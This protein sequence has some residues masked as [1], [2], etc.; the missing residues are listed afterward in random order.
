MTEANPSWPALPLKAWEPTRATLHMWT[1]IVGKVRLA[2][3]PYLNHWWQVP[4][5]VSP[6]G[7]ATSPIPAG[8]ESFE[9]LFDFL[10]HE[11]R[12]EKSDG[13]TSTLPLSPRPV[14]DFYA[15]VMAALRAIG[16]EARIWTMP[17]EIASPI[18]FEED[19]I[20]AAYDPDYARRFW[21]ILLSVDAVLKEF[22]GRFIG[23][24]SPV[25]FFWG[26]FDL[27]VT[28]FSGRRAPD[29][30][31]A[32]RMTREAYSHEVASVGWWPGE[33]AMAGPAFYAYAS[34]EPAG[35]PEAP[36]R[37]PGAAYDAELG[38]FL[39]DYDKVRLAPSPR[40]ALLDFCQSTYE[41]AAT[42]GNWDRAALEPIAGRYPGGV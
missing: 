4:L 34:P 11:L 15:D 33:G 38:Q 40:E 36:V 39:L 22:R 20:H 8:G 32:D 12:I 25:H 7:L 13:T 9:M 31:S 17:V 2:L 19:R 18:R 21:R 1:Q 42:L 26:S 3:S 10:A 30:A 41:A 14:A 16:I 35:F 23:K 29:R 27:T 37:P 24:S 6:R 28:R 5:Y